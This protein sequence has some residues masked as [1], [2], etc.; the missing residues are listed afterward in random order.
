MDS[1]LIKINDIE[2]LIDKD[3]NDL[4]NAIE[5]LKEANIVVQETF[6]NYQNTVDALTLL[7]TQL[8]IDKTY[9][10]TSLFDSNKNYLEEQVLDLLNEFYDYFPD[11]YKIYFEN[12]IVKEIIKLIIKKINIIYLAKKFSLILIYALDYLRSYRIVRVYEIIILN[13]IVFVIFIAYLN[14]LFNKDLI[15]FIF[16]KIIF[17]VINHMQKKLYKIIIYRTLFLNRKNNIDNN[18]LLNVF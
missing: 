14:S 17:I 5:K 12:I 18:I 15:C 8:E 2:T 7:N 10:K 4:N 9:Y 3:D 13:F 6:Q 16:Q 1:I 11:Q